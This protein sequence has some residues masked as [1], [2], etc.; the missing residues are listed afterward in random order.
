MRSDDF[1][2][3]VFPEETDW[4]Y[5]NADKIRKEIAKNRPKV[6]IRDLPIRKLPIESFQRVDHVVRQHPYPSMIAASVVGLLAGIL[7]ASI[8]SGD[9]D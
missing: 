2:L 9:K 1:D 5:P 4:E 3:E 6:R 8:V 7:V